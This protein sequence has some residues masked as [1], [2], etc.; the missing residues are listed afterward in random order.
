MNGEKDKFYHFIANQLFDFYKKYT[1]K[2]TQ[3]LQKT[4]L[5]RDLS[6]NASY[7]SANSDD[8]EETINQAYPYAEVQANMYRQVPASNIAPVQYGQESVPY[9]QVTEPIPPQLDPIDDYGM[10][11]S[12][13]H[14]EIDAEYSQPDVC[15]EVVNEPSYHGICLEGDV[16]TPII[17]EDKEIIKV[18]D[19]TVAFVLKDS[20]EDGM[21]IWAGGFKE[22]LIAIKH[23]DPI[24]T[25]AIPDSQQTITQIIRLNEL[26]FCF[27]DKGKTMILNF[28]GELIREMALGSLFREEEII[29]ASLTYKSSMILGT[30]HGTMIVTNYDVESQQLSV[31]YKEGD[32]SKYINDM[33]WLDIKKRVFLS[34]S[35]DRYLNKFKLTRTQELEVLMKFKYEEQCFCMVNLGE[36]MLLGLS[37]HNVGIIDPE[38]GVIVLTLNDKNNMM[39][40]RFS[41]S[42][43]T[44]V[45]YFFKGSQ[46]TIDL[47][48]Q[49]AK[50][51]EYDFNEY[52]RHLRILAKTEDGALYIFSYPLHQGN[53][54]ED[55]Q[56]IRLFGDNIKLNPNT[57]KI[58]LILERIS[59]SR[60]RV[61]VIGSSIET[62]NS[63]GLVWHS[64]FDIEL[65]GSG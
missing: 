50:L 18:G 42:C 13:H 38:T 36:F 6:K 62:N 61:R 26:Y 51:S 39:Q 52:M 65:N 56:I 54:N 9:Q 15:L 31:P 3:T 2:L 37:N 45:S 27:T 58:P 47:L 53:S 25:A 29:S 8:E 35:S 41:N 49:R 20:S 16:S 34:A 57:V 46:E 60:L 17:P 64:Q 44:S 7:V 21:C 28:S 59:S 12:S 23:L 11:G 40:E 48:S 4:D 19:G 43:F 10:G 63:E 32:H 1:Q 30:S 24:V 55:N 22:R 33:A 14:Q 5:S